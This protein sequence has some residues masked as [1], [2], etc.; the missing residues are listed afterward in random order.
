MYYESGVHG[1]WTGA[2]IDGYRVRVAAESRVALKQVHFKFAAQIISCRKARD[3]R[4]DDCNSIHVVCRSLSLLGLMPSYSHDYDVPRAV[5][6]CAKLCARIFTLQKWPSRKRSAAVQ[7]AS[8][9]VP[10]LHPSVVRM[11]YPIWIAAVA[12]DEA[13]RSSAT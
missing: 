11:A 12:Q 8:L 13:A 4:A 7:S 1:E 9:P 10:G 3:S 5:F 2:G 6:L